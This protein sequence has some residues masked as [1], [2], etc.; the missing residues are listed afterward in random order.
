LRL[1]LVALEVMRLRLIIRLGR[2]L[3]LQNRSV[4]SRARRKRCKWFSAVC[5]HLNRKRW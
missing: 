4:S 2:L 5:A 3:E 1:M